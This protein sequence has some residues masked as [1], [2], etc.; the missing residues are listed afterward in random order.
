MKKL[1]LTT[2]IFCACW[3]SQAQIANGSTA[4]DFTVTD[5]KGNV[6]VL[7]DYIAQGKTVILDV[8]A[9]WC[10]PCWNFHHSG[11]FEKLYNTYGQGGSGEVVVLFVEGDSN[12]SLDCLFGISEENLTWGNWVEHSSFPII[13]SSDLADLYEVHYFPT[14]FRI[15]PDGK[16]NEIQQPFGGVLDLDLEFLRENIS[17]NCTTLA[18]LQNHATP[19]VENSKVCEGSTAAPKVSLVNY[20]MQAISNATIELLN[21]STVIATTNFTG[22]IQFLNEA[23]V[24]FE[25]IEMAPGQ[26]YEAVITSINGVSPLNTISTRSGFDV[27]EA[28]EGY[29]N[30]TVKVYTNYY[31]EEI[32][33][34]IKN[35]SGS[36]VASGGPYLQGDGNSTKIHNVT[37]PGAA[38][39][40]YSV[41]FYSSSGYGWTLGDTAHGIDIVSGGETIFSQRVENFGYVLKVPAAFKAN[42]TLDMQELNIEQFRVYPNPTTGII[43]FSTKEELTV[44]VMDMTGKIVYKAESINDGDSINLS[45]M[46]KGIYIIRTES[47]DAQRTEKIIIN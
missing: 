7:S 27:V 32:S 4:P 40:C 10:S 41:E 6:H 35:S 33:W 28:T 46:Q 43:N 2:L 8:S 34:A 3:T 5:V 30:I 21:E 29:N 1:L 38:V 26:E 47:E 9:T 42:G 24:S 31:A 14:F 11:T 17:E 13:N 25:A 44:S 16:V 37:L 19:H 15:C 39:E 36:F 18:G 23:I 12:T 45:S 22:N 20:G